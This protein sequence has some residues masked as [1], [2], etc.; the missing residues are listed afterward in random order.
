MK[1]TI[2]RTRPKELPLTRR[3]AN[4]RRAEAGTYSMPSGDVSAAA[5]FCFLFAMIL[6]LP[7]IYLILPLVMCGRVFYQCHWFG[8]TIIGVV[9]GSFWGLITFVYF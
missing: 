2:K 1:Y 3:M 8:D 7:A 6:D 5:L 4:L 9:V